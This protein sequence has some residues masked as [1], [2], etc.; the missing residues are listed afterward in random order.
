MSKG[1]RR[2]AKMSKGGQ[3]RCVDTIDRLWAPLADGPSGAVGLARSEN[4]TLA[5]LGHHRVGIAVEGD[6]RGTGRWR[7]IRELEVGE[8][9]VFARG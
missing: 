1:G 7:G 9:A 3:A 4:P 6:E 2:W 5:R 8:P